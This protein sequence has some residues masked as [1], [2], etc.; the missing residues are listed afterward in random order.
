MNLTR[1]ALARTIAG[2]VAVALMIG[3]ISGTASATTPAISPDLP[4]D[5]SHSDARLPVAPPAPDGSDNYIVTLED[6]ASLLSAQAE[7][8]MVRNVSGPAFQGA[9]VSL[10]P[11]EAISLQKSAGVAA[12][13][14]D[15]VV[16]LTDD[17]KQPLVSSQA[18]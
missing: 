3:A 16:S 17:I 6:G 9:V 13:E 2:L 4:S 1:R 8:E 14:R 11:A 7:G 5:Q 12:V 18:T 10:T 15:S